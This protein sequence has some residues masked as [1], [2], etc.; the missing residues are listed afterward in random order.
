VAI[1]SYSELLDAVTTWLNKPDVEQSAPAFV[2]LAEADINR[3]LRHYR[4]Q[5]TASPSLSTQYTALPLDW[6]EAVRFSLTGTPWAPG[7]S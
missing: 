1:S 5:V 2:A 4:M 7:L 6:L 3:R